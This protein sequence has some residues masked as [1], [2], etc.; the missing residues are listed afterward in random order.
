MQI[1]CLLVFVFDHEYLFSPLDTVFEMFTVLLVYQ[2][3][4]CVVFK[5]LAEWPMSFFSWSHVDC[6]G[7]EIV[8]EV[9]PDVQLTCCDCFFSP[10]G[11]T[12]DDCNLYDFR[13]GYVFF[14]KETGFEFDFFSLKV[15]RLDVWISKGSL[16]LGRFQFLRVLTAS[17]NLELECKGTI[18]VD[19]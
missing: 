19:S 6:F 14:D 7:R 13:L 10:A 8:S 4:F 15:D 17:L 16:A 12:L 3:D 5:L 2:L 1:L 11:K 9:V 18:R